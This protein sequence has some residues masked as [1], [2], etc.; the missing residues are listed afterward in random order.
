M[1][2]E[3]KENFPEVG[4]FQ[5]RLSIDWIQTLLRERLKGLRFC[6]TTSYSKSQFFRIGNRR[7]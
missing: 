5:L 3:L 6:D 7:Y 4:Q 2:N 1:T